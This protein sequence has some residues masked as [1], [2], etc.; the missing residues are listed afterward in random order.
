MPILGTIASSKLSAAPNSYESIATYVVGSGSTSTVT[1]SSIPSTFKHLQVRAIIKSTTTGNDAWA[2]SLQGYL[3]SDTTVANYAYHRIRG[4]GGSID[5]SGAANAIGQLG[6][7]PS[8]GLTN[9]FAPTIIDILDYTDTSKYK[10]FKAINGSDTNGVAQQ[11]VGMQS[12][13][14]KNT[15]AVNAIE[16]RPSSGSFAQYTHFALYGIKGA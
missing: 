15:N 6:F 10:V 4:D 13:V 12:Q 11:F 14:W 2:W 8:A 9:I 5:T 7:I 16:L 1:F 3:N